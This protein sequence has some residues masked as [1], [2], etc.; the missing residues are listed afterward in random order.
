MF[1]MMNRP[2]EC[3]LGYLDMTID[4][5]L[6]QEELDENKG[7][8]YENSWKHLNHL[9]VPSQSAGCKAVV[10]RSTT[11]KGKPFELGDMQYTDI[12][13]IKRSL[14]EPQKNTVKSFH[15]SSFRF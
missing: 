14:N 7:L 3:I 10:I 15:N 11:I 8:I 2:Q 4:E 6:D 12:T 5:L 9:V 13:L 1:F